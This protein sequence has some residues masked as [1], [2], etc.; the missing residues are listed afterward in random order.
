MMTPRDAPGVEPPPPVAAAMKGADAVMMLT[1][2]ALAPTRARAQAQDAGARILGL[3]GYDYSVLQ[4][5]A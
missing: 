2:Y 4:S 3:E 5:E 1:T